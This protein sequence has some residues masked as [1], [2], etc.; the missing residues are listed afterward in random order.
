MRND[1]S[2]VVSSGNKCN[3]CIAVHLC[4]NSKG[5]RK[6]R[7]DREYR[8]WL[9]PFLCKNLTIVTDNYSIEEVHSYYVRILMLNTAI[10]KSSRPFALLPGFENLGHMYVNIRRD[11]GKIIPGKPLRIFGTMY[12]YAH[13]DEYNPI[14]NIGIM[15]CRFDQE[16]PRGAVRRFVFL[17]MII[18]MSYSFI[19]SNY[20]KN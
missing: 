11:L 13:G 3:S 5:R 17:I 7:K 10:Q 15:P 12:E 4:W 2:R 6:S 9:S 16:L 19:T 18:V 8:D 14:R 20:S 1:F